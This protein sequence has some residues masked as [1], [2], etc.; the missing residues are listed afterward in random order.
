MSA[1]TTPENSSTPPTANERTER[2]RYQPAQIEPKWQQ[3]WTESKIFE[4]SKRAISPVK[5]KF[6]YLD[7]FPYPSGDL[8]VGHVRNYAIGD[9]VAR[10]HVMRGADVLHPMGW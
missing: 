8:H 3:A 1:Q 4:T 2:E 9:A 5:P 10:Y 7:M 6:Y